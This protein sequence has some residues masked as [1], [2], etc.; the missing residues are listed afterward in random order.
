MRV[1]RKISGASTK[2]KARLAAMKAWLRRTCGCHFPTRERPE[3]KSSAFENFQNK[4]TELIEWPSGEVVDQNFVISREQFEDE[5]YWLDVNP[6]DGTV[7]WYFVKGL[8]KRLLG[9]P[10]GEI[11]DSDFQITQEQLESVKY[12]LDI[13]QDTGTETWYY[14]EEDL[15][16]LFGGPA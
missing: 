5:R 13:D 2:S 16:D 15:D 9:W 4:M 1:S 11:L 3:D 10:S 6:D 7:T 14:I 12:W 8:K